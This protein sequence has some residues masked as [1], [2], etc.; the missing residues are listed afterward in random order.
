M[1]TKTQSYDI[2]FCA[3]LQAVLADNSITAASLCA[4][5]GIS[6]P[7]MSRLLSGVREPK[8]RTL[9]R[10]VSALPETVDVRKLLLGGG[11]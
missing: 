9:Q 1:S 10:V 3:R 2:E 8:L 11:S 7:N 5:T 4:T 6:P